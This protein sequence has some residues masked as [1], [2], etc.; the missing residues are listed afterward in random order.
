MHTTCN[1]FILCQ[2]LN[3]QKR[4]KHQVK[5]K[6][7]KK[8]FADMLFTELRCTVS[9]LSRAMR[10]PRTAD[11]AD[12][13]DAL[14]VASFSNILNE[15]YEYNLSIF[16][17]NSP[18][19][20]IELRTLFVRLYWMLALILLSHSLRLYSAIS[21]TL[22]FCVSRSFSSFMRIFAASMYVCT[23]FE[24]WFFVDL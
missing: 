14:L 10:V 1:R 23:C 5:G 9:Q 21:R 2:K 6:W 7:K 3:Q 4:H 13:V 11:V 24:T 15:N 8:Y 12:E 19:M 16:Y 18:S 17:R 22:P 20:C